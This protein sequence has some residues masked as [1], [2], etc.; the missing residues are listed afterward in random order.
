HL[1]KLPL[2]NGRRPYKPL[3][4]DLEGFDVEMSLGQQFLEASVL[5]FLISGALQI[6]AQSATV[7]GR[8]EP[9]GRLP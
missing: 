8:A 2:A 3:L 1:V 6:G 5:G 4:G 7:R 9:F